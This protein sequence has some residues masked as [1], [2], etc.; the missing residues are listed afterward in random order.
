MEHFLSI[1]VENPDSSKLVQFPLTLCLVIHLS[2]LTV[3]NISDL[4]VTAPFIMTK[5]QVYFTFKYKRS[6]D[7]REV[8]NEVLWKLQDI[9]Q[10]TQEIHVVS[11]LRT[12]YS[13]AWYKSLFKEG[14]QYR[15]LNTNHSAISSVH[16]KV[17][18]CNI[19][20]FPTPE[21]GAQE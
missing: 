9:Y 11:P 13:M 10:V 21:R 6:I 8:Q 17:I 5:W 3:E 1:L 12:P 16:N 4:I 15:S 14:Y 20:W 18:G 2:R 7:G 19:R